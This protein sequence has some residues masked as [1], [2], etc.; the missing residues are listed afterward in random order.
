MEAYEAGG[1]A[2]IGDLPIGEGVFTEDD[3][4]SAGDVVVGP[5]ALFGD[6][7]S[8]DGGISAARIDQGSQAD[9]FDDPD[10]ER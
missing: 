9:V 8:V 6:R 1:L 5:L 4:A 10:G 7:V 2:T 3:V